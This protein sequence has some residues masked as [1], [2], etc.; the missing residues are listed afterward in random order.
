MP[1]YSKGKI[2]SLR[3][4]QTD[5]I[6]I[7]STIETLSARKAKHKADYKRFLK[8][9]Q[10]YITSYEILKFDDCYIELIENC[11]CKDKCE[12]EKYEGKFIREM[13]CVNK[14]IAGRTLK[15][16][17]EEHKEEIAEKNKKYRETHKEQIRK[18]EKKYREKNKDKIAERDKKYREK[19]IE[20]IK[21]K[22]KI[23]YETVKKQQF[24]KFTCECGKYLIK[25]HEKSYTHQNWLKTGEQKVIKGEKYTCECGSTLT[26]VKKNR[27]ETS[28]KHQNYLKSLE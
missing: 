27:H 16:Y 4:H 12:L 18:R 23:R 19:N 13:D 22:D 11:P 9:L 20:E 2:Y 28:Q 24:I 15:E 21:R 25:G 5:D 10:H 7:G 1:D 6:Y 14:H 3:S 8:G 17:R 26:K